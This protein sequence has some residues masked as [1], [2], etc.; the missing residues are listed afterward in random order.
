MAQP[1]PWWQKTTIYQI[2]PRSFA[3]SNNDGIGDLQGIISK[4]DYIQ[5]LGFETIWLS[6][7]F[8]SPQQDFGYDISDYKDVAP[9][10]GTLADVEN[11]ITE[12][13]TRGM[14]VLFDLVLNH[15]SIQ[16]PWF[17]ESRSIRDNPKRNWYIWRDGR[18]TGPPN[19]WKAIPG[20]SGWHYD[21]P[22]DQWYFASFLPFQPDLNWHNPEVK[23]TMLDIFRF[24]LD[25]GVDGYRLDIFHS[26]YKDAQFRENPFSYRYLPESGVAGFFQEWKYSLHQPEAYE[27]ARELST[28]LGSYSP[29]R[30]MVG[31]VFGKDLTIK[32][33]IGDKLDGFNILFSWDLLNLKTGVPLLQDVIRHYEALFPS[34]YTPIYV[35]GNHDVKRLI[36]QIG[37]DP[38][39]AKLLALFQFTVRGLPV[40]YYGEEIGMADGNF[41]N[42][43]S[44]DPIAQRYKHIPQFVKDLLGVYTNRDGCRTPMQWDDGLNAGFCNPGCTPWL[45]V[46]ENR[47]RANVRT[48][49][50][51]DDSILNTYRKL[52]SLRREVEALHEGS[53]ELIDGPE[54]NKNLLVYK[55]QKESE[56]VLIVINFGKK[57]VQFQNPTTCDRVLLTV[58]MGQPE[59]LRVVQLPP[60]AGVILGN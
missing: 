15:T 32:E 40:T 26:V 1:L 49:K 25:K 47:I 39:I 59:S 29:E 20:G 37:G 33:Y 23:Q 6:P 5:D 36:S 19:N 51:D 10:Y 24:W 35:F 41:P 46:H 9:E 21:K 57:R 31:E 4:L 42:G 45:P 52:L 44:L 38:L 3:D 28:I 30:I 17:L 55:R 60:F 14:R 2:Y 12:V 58:G 48:Q 18:G 34:P 16:H 8:S 27:L 11:L 53:L 43:G 7:F 13:H 54:V 22:T 56:T 50:E